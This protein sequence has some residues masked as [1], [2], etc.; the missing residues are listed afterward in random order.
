M[1]AIDALKATHQIEILITRVLQFRL[2]RL[3]G[4]ALTRISW[5]KRPLR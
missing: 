4:V 2:G 3:H 1:A 5:V